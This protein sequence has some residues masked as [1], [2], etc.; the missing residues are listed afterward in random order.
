[1]SSITVAVTDEQMAKLNELAKR[2]GVSP[3]DLLRLRIDEMLSDHDEKFYDA[4]AR[5]LRKNADLYRRLA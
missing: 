2:F 3:E 5:A 4:A 1:M